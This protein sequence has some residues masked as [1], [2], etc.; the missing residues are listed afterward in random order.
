MFTALIGNDENITRTF[1]VSVVLHA[2]FYAE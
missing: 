2:F 1:L